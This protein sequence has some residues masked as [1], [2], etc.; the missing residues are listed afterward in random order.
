MSSNEVPILAKPDYYYSEDRDDLAALV[1]GG[2]NVVLE[3]GCGK[4]NTGFLLRQKHRTSILVGIEINP[5]MAAAAEEIFDRVIRGDVEKMELPAAYG[6]YDYVICGD[7]LE[8]LQDPWATLRKVYAVLKPGGFILASI[9]TLRNWRVLRDLLFKGEFTY[10]ESGTL[11]ITHLRFFTKKSMQK[12][13]TDCHFGELT[14]APN[15]F[16]GKA[17]LLNKL[18]LGIFEEF[19]ALRYL[20]RARKA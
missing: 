18:T 2:D 16:G 8:H 17:S 5:D 6:L 7:V 14:I 4:G 10:R 11:D 9:P 13:F 3:I 1:E 15:T 20:I 19:W 12:L